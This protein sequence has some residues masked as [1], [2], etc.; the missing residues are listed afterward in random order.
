MTELLRLENIN[1]YAKPSVPLVSNLSLSVHSGEVLRV[2]SSSGASNTALL[3]L[4]IKERTPHS[5]EGFYRGR[6]LWGR[7]SWNRSELRQEIG[8][9]FQDDYLL[10]N[11]NVF[12]NVAMPLQMRGY[13]AHRIEDRAVQALSDVGLVGKLQSDTN[14]LPVSE[15]RLLSLARV[16][17]KMPPL[18]LA[19]LGTSD[20]DQQVIAKRLEGMASY[21]CGVIIF[22]NSRISSPD[23]VS[24]ATTVEVG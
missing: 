1:Y 24:A 13:S 15:R 11:R 17:A 19:D 4:L 14:T 6:P 16:L 23:P 18:V 9:I 22:N 20:I 12:E 5:G 7:N 3:E 21:S 10:P 2:A 8:V